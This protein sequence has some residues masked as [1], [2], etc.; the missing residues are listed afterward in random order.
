MYK[1]SVKV[2]LVNT[3]D[4]SILIDTGKSNLAYGRSNGCMLEKYI[5]KY[6]QCLL[7]GVGLQGLPLHLEISVLPYDVNTGVIDMFPDVHE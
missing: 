6:I 7:R 5:N 3:S 1:H 4:G 2:R